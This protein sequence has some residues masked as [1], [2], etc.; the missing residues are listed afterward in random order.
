L[1][2]VEVLS[3]N[4][5]RFDLMI[6]RQLYAEFGIPSYWIVDIAEPA[7]QILEL[8]DGDYAERTRLIGGTR[9][10]LDRPFTVAVAAQD[11]V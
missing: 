7:I 3:P 1:L 5:R 2:V 9:V 6:K 11:V 4:T 8:D 10:T